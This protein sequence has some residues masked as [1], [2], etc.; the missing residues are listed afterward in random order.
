GAGRRRPS[1]SVLSWQTWA[2]GR[3]AKAPVL[4][5]GGR[6]GVR[7]RSSDRLRGCGD[8]FRWARNGLGLRR[9]RGGCLGLRRLD[10]HA[11]AVHR[12]GLLV[13]DRG[14]LTFLVVRGYDARGDPEGQQH[15]RHHPHP[16]VAPGRSFRL[17]VFLGRVAL[18]G[19]AL[20]WVAA[21]RLPAWLARPW[22][23]RLLRPRRPGGA[24]RPRW[25]GRSGR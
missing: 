18:L 2:L 20:L 5:S 1:P 8:R 10:V 19:I 9:D 4:W 13:D 16:A 12:R 21:G 24:R 11:K 25:L 23:T 17:T 7:R 3:G 14:R 6:F 15:H 22:L